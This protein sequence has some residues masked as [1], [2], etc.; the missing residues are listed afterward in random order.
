[1]LAPA[2]L[3]DVLRPSAAAAFM[4]KMRRSSEMLTGA[5]G[6]PI[7]VG[8]LTPQRNAMTL[9]AKDSQSSFVGVFRKVFAS[10]LLQGFRGGSRPT[11]AAVPQFTAI[12]PVYLVAEEKLG[13]TSAALFSAALAESLFTYSAQRRNAQ[14]Q[15]NATRTAAS[16][17]LA[18][19]SVHR[20]VGPGFVPHVGRNAFAMMGI[21]LWSPHSYEFIC[22]VPGAK[23]LPE[24]SRVVASDLASSVVAATISM[25]MNH[26][27]SWAACTPEL[28]N[29]SY[30]ARA[31]ASC[32]WVVGNYK[33]Q[34]VRLLARDLAL[35]INYTAFLFTGYRFVE[36]NLIRWSSGAE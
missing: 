20:L 33:E 18:L 25:P 16:E 27:F 23:A 7:V 14:I 24:E 2:E 1:M 21:R 5:V 6:G 30:L 10:G 22:S 11:L 31:K 35:R 36:R 3:G 29:M 12:G 4:A 28:G 17:M 8:F 19:H 26:M 32:Q 13:S 34:G 15:Y 9:A